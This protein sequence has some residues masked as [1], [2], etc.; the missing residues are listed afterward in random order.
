MGDSREARNLNRAYMG[1]D[2]KDT[3]GRS[4]TS[5][6]LWATCRG[7]GPWLLNCEDSGRFGQRGDLLVSSSAAC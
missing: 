4:G 2:T 7:V 1:E 3:I 5:G 6:C